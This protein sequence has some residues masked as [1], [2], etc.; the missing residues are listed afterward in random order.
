[1]YIN[2]SFITILLK[3]LF[4]FLMK[5]LKIILLYNIVVILYSKKLI[6][7]MPEDNYQ[8]INLDNQ[9]IENYLKNSHFFVFIHNSWCSLSQNLEKILTKIN[10]FLKLESQPFYI[11]IIDD[12]INPIDQISILT[13]L[14]EEINYPKILYFNEGKFIKFYNGIYS[15]DDILNWI[16]KIIYF[17]KLQNIET[18]DELKYKLLN[19]KNS[20]L[21]LANEEEIK[22]IK[23]LE[24]ESL[25][26][27]E[28]NIDLANFFIY[29][30]SS[31]LKYCDN[32]VFFYSTNSDIIKKYKKEKSKIA[33]F[34]LGNITN[35]FN[36]IE[37][38]ILIEEKIS[39]FCFKCTFKN[40]YLNFGEDAIEKVFIKRTPSIILFRN[41]FENKTEYEEIKLETISWMKRELNVI[42][43]DI[44]TKYSLKLAQLIGVTQDDLPSIR[45]IDFNGNNNTIRV[46]LYSKEIT[47]ENILDFVE[48]WEDNKLNHYKFVQ[49]IN[50]KEKKYSP[51]LDIQMSLFYEKV[52]MNRKNVLIY[53]YSSWC[54]HCKK[55]INLFDNISK[56]LNLLVISLIQINIGNSFDD[57]NKIKKVPLIVF[58]NNNKNNPIIFEGKL[59]SI[60]I[61][62]FLENQN[63][64]ILKVK[65]DL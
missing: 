63:P 56:K 37:E 46:F 17:P 38:D 23:Y 16:R 55:H 57:N 32:I 4:I 24:N 39:D 42:I 14:K 7:D 36:L 30:N 65:D 58:Y 28:K 8:L 44:D 59:N 6:L 31:N 61:L 51:V 5:V 64:N 48:K 40:L 12:T 50:S 47:S 25:D 3:N 9:N 52:I 18:E 53:Y 13:F 10:L 1:M 33:Y 2:Q 20:F 34:S 54:S 27:S 35:Y 21:Y 22:F 41:K 19:N 45:L 11:G 62:K 49:K 43:T 60:N 26:E 29:K 15:F